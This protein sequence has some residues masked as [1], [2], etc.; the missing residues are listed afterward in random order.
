MTSVEIYH[1]SHNQI[2]T[3]APIRVLSFATLGGKP[4]LIIR[5]TQPTS[6]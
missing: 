3:R 4:Y 6:G 5:D 2:E 1:T